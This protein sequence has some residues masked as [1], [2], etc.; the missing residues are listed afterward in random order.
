MVSSENVEGKLEKPQERW[1]A[2]YINLLVA[3]T[4]FIHLP[5][6]SQTEQNTIK[7][8]FLTDKTQQQIIVSHLQHWI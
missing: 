4:N 2:S 1:K 6:L 3:L 7:Q 8:Y 5:S